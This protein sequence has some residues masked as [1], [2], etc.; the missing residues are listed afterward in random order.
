MSTIIQTVKVFGNTQTEGWNFRKFISTF[1]QV[2][3]TLEFAH[4][5]GVVHQRYKTP[6]HYDW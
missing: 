4:S 3:Q 2:A 6:K 1:I 5:R